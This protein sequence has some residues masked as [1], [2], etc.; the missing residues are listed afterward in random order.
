M[1]MIDGGSG[2]GGV[3]RKGLWDSRRWEADWGMEMKT[4]AAS[5]AYRSTLANRA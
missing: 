2:W 1:L 3:V 4:S 5:K